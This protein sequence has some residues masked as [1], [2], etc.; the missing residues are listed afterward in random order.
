MNKLPLVDAQTFEK[1]LLYLGLKLSDR[2]GAMY[3][4]N[5]PMDVILHCLTTKEEIL[6]DR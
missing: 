6:E 3:F 4:I 1:L 2:K 5:I